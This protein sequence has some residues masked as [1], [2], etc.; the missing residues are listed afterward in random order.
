M[1]NSTIQWGQSVCTILELLQL[2]TTR[3][4][5]TYNIQAT[6][7]VAFPNPEAFIIQYEYLYILTLIDMM[8]STN[9]FKHV[10]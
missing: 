8:F 7:H 1:F 5:S 4:H 9:Y 2:H 10:I 3:L 6:L